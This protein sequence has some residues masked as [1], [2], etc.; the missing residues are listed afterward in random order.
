MKKGLHTCERTC[1]WP[2]LAL[3]TTSVANQDTGISME[4]SEKKNQ[5]HTH[6]HT[7]FPPLPL[8]AISRGDNSE[9]AGR[10]PSYKFT[11]LVTRGKDTQGSTPAYRPMQA[12][13]T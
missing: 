6:T 1:I 13:D 2:V 9:S 8:L 11:L 5:T 4:A 10:D 7:T 12:S 3:Y